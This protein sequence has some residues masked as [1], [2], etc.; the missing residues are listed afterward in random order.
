MRKNY[1]SIILIIVLKFNVAYS[2]IDVTW[3]WRWD[4][5]SVPALGFFPLG[6]AKFD[7]ISLSTF[8]G[9]PSVDLLCEERDK[10]RFALLNFSA[11]LVGLNY[12]A[13]QPQSE[14]S[15]FQ[16]GY[17][18]IGPHYRWAGTTENGRF[19]IGGQFGYG[20][21]LEGNTT[22]AKSK[23]QHGLE[24]SLTFSWTPFGDR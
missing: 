24:I 3:D 7:N 14:A 8:I 10:S 21:L 5:R 4:I 19:A 2:Q 22:Q 23:I 12:A 15:V 9:G 13:L 1:F 17:A 16:I 18:R 11:Y 6:G 20:A